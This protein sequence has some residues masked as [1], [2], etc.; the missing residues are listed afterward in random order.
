MTSAS[1]GSSTTSSACSSIRALLLSRRRMEG[2][3]HPRRRRSRVDHAAV[4]H[5]RSAIPRDGPQSNPARFNAEEWVALAKAAG[6][7]YLVITAK[8]HDGFAMYHS[9]VSPYNIV[10]WTPFKRDPV[11]ELSDACR[12]PAS[13]SASTTRIVR[14]GM[15]PMAM[16][17]TGTT[18]ARK[19]ISI[20][21]WKKNPNLS[22]ASSSPT[23]DLWDWSGLTAAWIHRSTPASS[24]K[25]CASCNPGA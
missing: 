18:T 23:T 1:S 16:A 2:Q 6:M 24:S 5:S 25:W 14:I 19:R 10:D 13:A 17:I 22:Y 15:I 21:T 3:P 7:K 8:H 4:Q 11:K 20:A 12:K 9:Q